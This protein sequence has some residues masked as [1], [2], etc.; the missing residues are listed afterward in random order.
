MQSYKVEVRRIDRMHAEALVRD[1]SLTL[2][3]RRADPAAGFNPVETLLSAVGDCLLTSLDHV[4]ETSR[5]AIAEASVKLEA[6]RQE[7]PPLLTHIRYTLRIRSYATD[8]RLEHLVELGKAHSTVFETIA[9]AVPV[10]G[11]WQRA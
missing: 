1:F 4:A 7:K 8:E 3:A 9:Q 11:V 5:V 2:G 6:E 10:E